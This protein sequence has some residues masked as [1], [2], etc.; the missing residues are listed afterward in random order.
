VYR[1][2]TTFS[3][4]SGGAAGFWI[5]RPGGYELGFWVHRERAER[6]FIWWALRGR[7]GRVCAGFGEESGAAT[8]G[9]SCSSRVLREG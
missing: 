7:G 4:A 8:P 9:A 5:G 6:G 3:I 1:R 2:S